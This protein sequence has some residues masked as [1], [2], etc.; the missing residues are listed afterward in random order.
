MAQ[1]EALL[2]EA[3]KIW[4]LPIIH[5]SSPPSCR[6]SP[7]VSLTVFH[8]LTW[9]LNFVKA[10][11]G[12]SVRKIANLT[13]FVRRELRENAVLWIGQNGKWQTYV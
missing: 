13:T 9:I 10:Y 6:I 11:W 1:V 2:N 3:T 4:Q 12:I 5:K 7:H 8:T